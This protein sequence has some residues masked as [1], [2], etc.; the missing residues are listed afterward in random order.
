MVEGTSTLAGLWEIGGCI[1]KK[2]K[3]TLPPRLQIHATRPDILISPSCPKFQAR[4]SLGGGRF[5][6]S[7]V[8]ASQGVALAI[9][10]RVLV[11]DLL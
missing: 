3:D 7:G 10:T 2:P 9:R 4:V 8:R 1:S 11:G 5:E 6:C